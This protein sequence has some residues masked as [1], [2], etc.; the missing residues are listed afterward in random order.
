VRGDAEMMR[1]GHHFGI[2]DAID[3]SDHLAVT[4]IHNRK[5]QAIIYRWKQKT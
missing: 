3:R 2:S 4:K 5:A 1:W